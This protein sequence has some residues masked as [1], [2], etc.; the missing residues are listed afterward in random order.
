MYHPD[1]NEAL[2]LKERIEEKEKRSREGTTSI[3]T[4]EEINAQLDRER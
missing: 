4:E 3:Q 2:L 1:S